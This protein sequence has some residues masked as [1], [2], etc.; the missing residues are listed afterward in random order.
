MPRW[1][2]LPE[3]LDPEVRELTAA[4]RMLVDRGG[5]GLA[6]VADSTG[7]SRTS[8]ERYL[9]GRLLPPKGAVIALA[10]VTGV[11]P[12]HL[13]TLW[14]LAER[15]WSRAEMRH[16]LTIEAMR[17]AQAREGLGE[18]AAPSAQRSATVPTGP[19]TGSDSAAPAPPLTAAPPSSARAPGPPLVPGPA[20]TPPGPAAARTTTPAPETAPP[21]ASA[22]TGT[23]A[24]VPD[25][26][27]TAP[28][29]AN[30][31]VTFLA[32]TVGALLI[33]GAAVFLTQAD[34]EDEAR[35]AD[36]GSS[37]ATATGEASLPDGVRCQGSGCAGEDP[38]AMGCGGQRATTGRS[39]TVGSAVLE[40]RFSEVCGAAWARVTG[41]AAGDAVTV[42]GEGARAPER[43]AEV[44]Q[45]PDA[46]TPMVAVRRAQDAKACITP[47]KG[48]TTCTG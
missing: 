26:P 18:F 31:V 43:K 2:P 7:Y 12:L 11:D 42:G 23:G 10:E 9:N 13:T 28:G 17:I 24:A 47:V 22:G 39:I 4:L 6:A 21:P 44:G 14:E 27:R 16:D 19:A 15:S 29:R 30:R 35:A 48:R 8:W 20:A 45:D 37:S 1:K 32:G 33:V 34:P 25:G 41:A 5:A 38:E 40:V 46:Y 3:E 36:R